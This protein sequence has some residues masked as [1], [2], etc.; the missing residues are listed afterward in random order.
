M[1]KPKLSAAIYTKRNIRIRNGYRVNALINQKAFCVGYIGVMF[2][3]HQIGRW[4]T[5]PTICFHAS[6]IHASMNSDL[7]IWELISELSFAW[8]QH[9]NDTEA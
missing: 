5:Y 7:T 8:K 1:S 4:W 3:M 9:G 6:V 2:V